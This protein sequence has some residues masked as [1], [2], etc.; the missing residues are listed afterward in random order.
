MVA[1]VSADTLACVLSGVEAPK[2][3]GLTRTLTEEVGPLAASG[4]STARVTLAQLSWLW[5]LA[6]STCGDGLIALRAAANVEPGHYAALEALAASQ[7]T[8]GH[9]LAAV[10][11][12]TTLI[13][14]LLD[15]TFQREGPRYVFA[16]RLRWESVDAT[17]HSTL[18]LFALVRRIG[19]RLAGR[20]LALDATLISTPPPPG[21]PD[22]PLVGEAFGM[23]VRFNAGRDALVFAEDPYLMPLPTRDERMRL[24]LEDYVRLARTSAPSRCLWEGRVREVLAATGT[25]ARVELNA[26]A[27]HLGASPR[28]L[29]RRLASEGTSF[30]AIRVEASLLVARAELLGGARVEQ[31]ARR[32]GFES[33]ATFGRAFKQWTGAAP[34]TWRASAGGR[35]IALGRTAVG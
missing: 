28:Q 2:R 23:G 11:A 12:A 14:D 13:H 4:V 1:T 15:C 19:A 5:R 16:H 18:L 33:A 24:V 17:D 8:L 3:T 35:D 31:V 9:A 34:A 29:Q 30:E 21:A 26:V 27:A 10:A 6:G 22:S 7:P 25:E 20:P 32:L